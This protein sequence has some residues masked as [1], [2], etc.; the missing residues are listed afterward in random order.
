MAVSEFVATRIRIR[1]SIIFSFDF[2]H[3]YAI[4]SYY[5]I[6]VDAENLHKI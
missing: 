6:E 5:R 1:T 3:I 2:M 4:N